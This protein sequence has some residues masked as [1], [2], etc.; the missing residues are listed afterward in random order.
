MRCGR[1][2]ALFAIAATTAP[3]RAAPTAA[4]V[5]GEGDAVALEAALV[6]AGVTWPDGLAEVAAARAAGAEPIAAMAGFAEVSNLIALGWRA[7]VAADPVFAA[8]RLG[9]ARTAAERLLIYDGG[10]A[11]YADASLRLGIALGHLGERDRADDALRL[12]HAL[13]PARAV[14]IAEFSPD[15]VAAYQA[16][17]AES[18]PT[19]TVRI[20]ALAGAAVT[21]DGRAVGVAPVSLAVPVGAHVIGL[22]AAGYAPLAQAVEIGAGSA[23]I[24]LELT[25]DRGAAAVARAGRAGFAALGERDAAAAIDAIVTYT[26][27][28]EVIVVAATR[29]TAGPALIGQRCRGGAACTAVVEVGYPLGGELATAAAVLRERLARADARYRVSLG[30]DARLRPQTPRRPGGGDGGA[31]RRWWWIGGGAAVAALATVVI[32]AATAADDGPTIA[33]DPGDFTR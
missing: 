5:V 30:G 33:V 24:A 25:P 31:R 28:E 17:V 9:A 21:V 14:T 6:A 10:A 16:A 8:N 11:L 7:Y 20:D 3:A 29:R 19:V 22:R 2:A 13:D 26:E 12:A 18:P 32:V 4:I 27:A 23:L 15:A 1:L